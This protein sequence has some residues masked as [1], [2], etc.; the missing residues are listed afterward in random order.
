M[1]QNCFGRSLTGS[2]WLAKKPLTD[3]LGGILGNRNALSEAND[4]LGNMG[5]AAAR[6]GIA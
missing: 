1:G 2:S 5:G 4:P 6:S 3:F